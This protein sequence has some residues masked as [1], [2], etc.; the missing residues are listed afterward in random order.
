L[1]VQ[2]RRLLDRMVREAQHQ[3]LVFDEDED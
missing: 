1:A 3:G 2:V